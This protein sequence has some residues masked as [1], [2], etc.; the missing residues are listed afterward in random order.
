MSR[1]LMDGLPFGDLDEEG[2]NE[3]YVGEY[4]R[5][6]EWQV[7]RIDSDEQKRPQGL[8][9]PDWLISSGD[10]QFLCEVKTVLSARR[11]CH[12]E[13]EFDRH[14]RTPL[15]NIFGEGRF[16]N[17]PYDVIVHNSTMTVP[18][19]GETARFSKWL[20]DSLFRIHQGQKPRRWKR[21]NSLSGYFYSGEYPL[22]SSAESRRTV[23]VE[24]SQ[25]ETGGGV[26]ITIPA[27]GSINSRSLQ[28][29]IRKAKQQLDDEAQYRNDPTMPRVV[30]IA[31][32]NGLQFDWSD[33]VRV[34]SDL[35]RRYTQLS[36]AAL[37][38]WV[39]EEGDLWQLNT[40]WHLAFHVL[41]NPWLKGTRAL[42]LEVFDD[43]SSKQE[44]DLD[45]LIARLK[46]AGV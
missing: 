5:R 17:L 25:R 14:F 24:V 11:G 20:E 3:A 12:Q 39:S 37:F 19:E 15:K 38:I 2:R 42:P 26:R 9:K 46:S 31:V 6:R 36:A 43:G 4:F 7:D 13:S 44:H 32:H 30:A 10:V 41:H 22:C 27:Y 40:R 8:H 33:A 1:V 16:H 23:D 18:A 29:C 45:G 21:F 28:S 35:L 34:V